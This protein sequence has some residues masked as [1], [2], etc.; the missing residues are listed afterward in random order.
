MVLYNELIEVLAR[1]GGLLWRLGSYFAELV[2]GQR[3]CARM[4]KWCLAA[5]RESETPLRQGVDNGMVA[6][7]WA[8]S[9]VL[10]LVRISQ[11]R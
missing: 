1:E 7:V 9:L 2:V 4:R 3:H 5:A 10:S 6:G 11:Q 8:N